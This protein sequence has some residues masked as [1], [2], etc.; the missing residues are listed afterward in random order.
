[1]AHNAEA[2]GVL[3]SVQLTYW[4]RIPV[5]LQLKLSHGWHVA[6]AGYAVPPPPPP[7]PETRA[8][9]AERRAHMSPSD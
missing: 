9:I 3:R 5:P 8:L 4:Q 6:K 2:G 1:M 7:G